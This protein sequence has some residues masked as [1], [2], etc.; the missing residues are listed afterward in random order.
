M[1]TMAVFS[2]GPNLGVMVPVRRF[3]PFRTIMRPLSEP[4]PSLDK[5]AFS[6]Q[7]RAGALEELKVFIPLK[8]P[9]ILAFK[10]SANANEDSNGRDHHRITLVDDRSVCAFGDRERKR[11]GSTSLFLDER[12]SLH[13]A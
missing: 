13:T 9:L 12:V 8:E 7:T 10:V 4:G 5:V 1:Q 6:I 2:R 11:R 3:E